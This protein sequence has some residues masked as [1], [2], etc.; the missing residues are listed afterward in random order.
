MRLMRLSVRSQPT[1]ANTALGGAGGG[2]G[3]K[4]A[5]THQ[6][7]DKPQESLPITS[8]TH[9]DGAV[10]GD[11]VGGLEDGHALAR[12][13]PFLAAEGGRL[14]RQQPRVRRH[15]FRAPVKFG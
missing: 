10:G 7:F 8:T 5:K 14:E 4:R 12:E 9:G 6:A 13:A 11:G 15:L 1:S 3:A 2:R